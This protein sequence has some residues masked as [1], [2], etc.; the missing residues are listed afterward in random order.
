MCTVQSPSHLRTL[1][2]QSESPMES[3]HSGQ[4]HSC[5]ASAQFIHLIIEGT[6]FFLDPWRGLVFCSLIKWSPRSFLHSNPDPQTVLNIG[7][8]AWFSTVLFCF[9]WHCRLKTMLTVLL[10]VTYH[11]P[12]FT[13]LQENFLRHITNNQIGFNY[14]NVVHEKQTANEPDNPLSPN[15]VF[16]VKC[17]GSW[18]QC[19]LIS[20]DRITIWSSGTSEW[21]RG[22]HSTQS[23]L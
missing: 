17:P 6:H 3:L 19:F 13:R 8:C 9:L 4:Q 2:P 18:I 21:Q 20:P 14:F 22:K 15:H 1:L 16:M 12:R 10:Y 5:E 7:K 23:L 11:L